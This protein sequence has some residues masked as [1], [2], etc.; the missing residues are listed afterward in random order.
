[1][2]YSKYFF[3]FFFISL[4]F[5]LIFFDEEPLFNFSD[6]NIFNIVFFTIC[7]VSVVLENRF[8]ILNGYYSNND[9]NTF[10]Y[11]ISYTLNLFIYFYIVWFIFFLH[12]IVPGNVYLVDSLFYFNKIL[13]CYILI[14][15]KFLFLI[16]LIMFLLKIMLVSNSFNINKIICSVLLVITTISSIL[17]IFDF[18]INNNSSSISKKNNLNF[19]NSEKHSVLYSASSNKNGFD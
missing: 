10:M 17:L 7:V 1:M 9:S 14:L 5:G 12:L 16:L 3:F 8:K 6:L 2:V 11:S 13:N 19:F 18:S 4:I 15:N